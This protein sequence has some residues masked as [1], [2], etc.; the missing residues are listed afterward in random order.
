MQSCMWGA[1]IMVKVAAFYGD[2]QKIGLCIQ[3][4]DLPTWLYAVE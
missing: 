2:L 4:S 1:S 3:I